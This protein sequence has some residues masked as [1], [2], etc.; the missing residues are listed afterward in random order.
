ML[1]P[2]FHWRRPGNT[3]GGSIT[4]PLTS[5]LTGLESAVWQMTIFCF[6]LQNRLIQTS[7]IGGQR[8]SDTSPFRIPCEGYHDNALYYTPG[9][10]FK[11]N[12][13]HNKISC[14]IIH[15]ILALKQ[16]FQI[17]LAYFATAISYTHKIFMKSTPGPY[18]D[19][20]L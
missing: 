11:S 2:C 13:G 6:Y 15:C 1:K 17:A 8:Y 18:L 20:I 3:K 16:C 14:T 7:Q 5:C 9:V 19:P 12:H 10:I 4:V